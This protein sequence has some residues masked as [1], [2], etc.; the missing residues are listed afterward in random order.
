MEGRYQAHPDGVADAL[1]GYGRTIRVM[2]SRQIPKPNPQRRPV[3][4]H[5]LVSM[6]RPG[7]S[8][9]LASTTLA[10]LMSHLQPFHQHALTSGLQTFFDKSSCNIRLS[11]DRSATNCLS[12]RF[13]S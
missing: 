1:V 7:N 8:Q 5:A 2:L 9:H 4:S 6:A 3:V 13:Y 12:F 10:D 11:R